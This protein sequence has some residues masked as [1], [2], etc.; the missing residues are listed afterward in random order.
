[1]SNG[2]IASP[3]AAA[4]AASQGLYSVVPTLYYDLIAR[5]SPG[6]ALLLFFYLYCFGSTPDMKHFPAT[7]A[8]FV[9]VVLGYLVGII[10]TG[11]C[12][13]WDTLTFLV[14]GSIG[15]LRA[16]LGLEKPTLIE[17]WE[18]VSHRMESIADRSASGGQI[19]TKALAEVALCENLLTGAVCLGLLGQFTRA[20]MFY[21]VTS[22]L[23][24]YSLVILAL[25][26]SLLFRQAMF[27]GRV[28]SLHRLHS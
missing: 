15:K 11:F 5:I 4:P 23:V 13:V 17:Q 7:V 10:L 27:L 6:V 25:L 26:V 16:P 2:S 20:E 24:E 28:E 19:V 12:I 22:H 18:T 1:M 21:D 9:M 8:L 14:L 3:A